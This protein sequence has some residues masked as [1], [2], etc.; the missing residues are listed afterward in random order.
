MSKESMD[1]LK[2]IRRGLMDEIKTLEKE[3]DDLYK[4]VKDFMDLN[5][6]EYRK[7]P[8]KGNF[9]YNRA[10]IFELWYIK[11]LIEGLYE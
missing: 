3:E 4:T 1:T 10:I 6:E 11:R 9:L 2:K 5:L 8:I 7:D